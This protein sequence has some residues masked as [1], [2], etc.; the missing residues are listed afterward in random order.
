MKKGKKQKTANTQKRTEMKENI[1]QTEPDI[2]RK[3]KK[4]MEIEYTRVH[5]GAGGSSSI[6]HARA[7]NNRHN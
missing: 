5:K 4:I 2:K 3:Q 7:N 1:I 6:I